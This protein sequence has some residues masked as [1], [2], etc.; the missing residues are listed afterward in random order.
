MK[1]LRADLQKYRN[2]QIV[3]ALFLSS[4]SFG[5]IACLLIGYKGIICQLIIRHTFLLLIGFPD[6]QK[7]LS[8][9]W[10]ISRLIFFKPKNA[11]N[12]NTCSKVQIFNTF[13]TVA[14]LWEISNALFQYYLADYPNRNKYW[15]QSLLQQRHSFR[16]TCGFLSLIIA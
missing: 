2:Y 9:I 7:S 11:K 14:T 3:C 15:L 5:L 1:Q 4:M 10:Q 8:R 13:W 6:L 16:S 12:I